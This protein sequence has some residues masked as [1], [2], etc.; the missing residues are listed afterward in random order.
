MFVALSM[1][2]LALSDFPQDKD[3]VLILDTDNFDAAIAAN[4]YILGVYDLKTDLRRT[5]LTLLLLLINTF[6][7]S[8]P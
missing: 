1:V 6:L 3:G 4:K 8:R 5:V 7:V 2:A